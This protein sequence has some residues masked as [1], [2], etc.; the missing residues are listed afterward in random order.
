[1]ADE[2]AIGEHVRPAH[3]EGRGGGGPPGAARRRRRPGRAVR[4]TTRSTRR[5]AWANRALGHAEYSPNYQRLL[6]HG[7]ATDVGDLLAAGDEA[8]VVERLRSFRDAGVTDLAVRVLPFGPTRDA[9]IESR[10]RVLERSW[11]RSAPSSEPA[12]VTPSVAGPLA[13]IRVLEVGHI[14]AG[15]FARDAARRPRRRRHQDRARAAATSRGR[16]GRSTSVSTTCTSRASTATS[17]ACTSTSRPTTDRRSSA[18][19]R[20][21]AHALLVNL[22]PSTIRTLGLDYESLRRF[23]PRIVCVALT[24]YGLDGPAA[25]WPAFDYVIQASVGVAGHDRRARRAARRSPA[26]RPSTTRRAIMAALGLVAKVLE[27]KGGQVDVSLFDVMLVAAQLQG[28]GLPQRR[29]RA[30]PPGRSARTRSTC[31]RSC[32]RRPTGTSRCS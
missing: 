11:R 16:S 6:E 25:E 4:A 31:P 22:R 18:R 28:R 14:L 15:P 21:T 10:Q 13:G 29:R 9:R 20:E 24:G 32:S 7:D 12:F 23:N 17:A 5:A 8:A 27:G 30:R 1:M 2:R 3:H 19:S 26:T